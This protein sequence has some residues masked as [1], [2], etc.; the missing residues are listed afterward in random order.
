MIVSAVFCG[1]MQ[2]VCSLKRR[3][4]MGNLKKLKDLVQETID[5]GATSVEEVHQAIAAMPLDVLESIEVLEEPAKN[6]KEIRKKTIGGVYNII[7][8]INE[9]VADIADDIINRVEKEDEEE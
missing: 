4:Y 7:R 3:Y 9:K 1:I 2:S 8:T 6:I 5:K